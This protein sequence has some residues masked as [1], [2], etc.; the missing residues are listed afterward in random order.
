MASAELM[1]VRWGWRTDT[2]CEVSAKW[3]LLPVCV[4]VHCIQIASWEINRIPPLNMTA[5][6]IFG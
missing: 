2:R 1:M 3:V 5:A 6:D 4:C